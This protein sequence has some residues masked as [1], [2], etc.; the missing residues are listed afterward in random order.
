MDHKTHAGEVKLD[1]AAAP[2]AACQIAVDSKRGDVTLSLSNFGGHFSVDA[3]AASVS[4][5]AIR[6]S[7][8]SWTSVGQRDGTIGAAQKDTL[9]ITAGGSATILA[10]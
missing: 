4:G 3:S 10:Q 9:R 6:S 8:A 5:S 1:I 7:L 2:T